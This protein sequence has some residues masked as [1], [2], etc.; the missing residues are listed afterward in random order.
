MK[1]NWRWFIGGKE[2]FWISIVMMVGLMIGFTL[3][4]IINPTEKTQMEP[5]KVDATSI[6][7]ISENYVR[8]LGIEVDKPIKYRFVRYRSKPSDDTILL[9][10]FHEW[11]GIY[12][13]DISVN[14]YK[15]SQLTEVVIHETRHMIVE[16]LRD[17]KVID[18]IKYTEEIAQEKNEYYN[19]LFNN[20]V[21][22]LKERGN[23]D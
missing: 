2:M 17:Q 19:N 7:E 13:I 21:F 11:N 14:L 4:Y 9:G 5:L 18:L 1:W 3:T 16:Y 23:N 6:Q 12:H 10:T 22:L 8:L 15:S 20:S